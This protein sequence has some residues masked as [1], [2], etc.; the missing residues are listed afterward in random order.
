[1]LMIWC[2]YLTVNNIICKNKKIIE[3]SL[4]IKKK[5]IKIIIN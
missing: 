2:I 5:M 4:K 3:N 1:M